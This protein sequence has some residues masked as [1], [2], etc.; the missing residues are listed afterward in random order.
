MPASI[1]RVRAVEG[2]PFA[3]TRRGCSSR[4]ERS[5]RTHTRTLPLHIGRRRPS[6]SGP[7]IDQ[8]RVGPKKG[9]Q[10]SELDDVPL[11]WPRLWLRSRRSSK[12]PGATPIMHRR[13]PCIG[14]NHASTPTRHRRQPWIGVN[15]GRSQPCIS[16]SHALFLL[17]RLRRH[18]PDGARACVET[19]ACT[20]NR[21]R[22]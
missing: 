9:A 17:H 3:D 11:L 22:P 4:P 15:R 18:V 21:P 6:I 5:V 16:A 2:P 14:A 8:P 12:R 13:Q 10:R 7:G 19:P 20:R 1:A